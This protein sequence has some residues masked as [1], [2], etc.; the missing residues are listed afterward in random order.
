M[1]TKKMFLLIAAVLFASVLY[2][3]STTYRI[4]SVFPDKPFYLQNV[5]S[6]MFLTPDR[7]RLY[8]RKAQ[9]LPGQFWEVKKLRDG[10]TLLT[11][12]GPTGVGAA[13]MQNMEHAL[14]SE[15]NI[16]PVRFIMVDDSTF[17]IELNDKLVLDENGGVGKKKDGAKVIWYIQTDQKNQQW[18]IILGDGKNTPFSAK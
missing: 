18:K 1:R 11:H 8:T 7:G 6:K 5:H 2:G 14:D 15:D 12:G 17:I 9:G 4:L 13:T 10:S 3:D 16:H